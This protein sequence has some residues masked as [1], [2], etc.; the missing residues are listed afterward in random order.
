MALAAD[1]KE[2]MFMRSVASRPNNKLSSLLCEQ[3]FKGVLNE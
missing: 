2:E 3:N 1:Q